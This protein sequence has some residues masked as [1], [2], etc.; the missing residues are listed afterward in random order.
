MPMPMHMMNFCDKFIE[1]PP[2][3]EEILHQAKHVSM[4]GQ[5]DNG[6]KDDLKG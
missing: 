2:L 6:E 1:I 5:M 4:D 3:S